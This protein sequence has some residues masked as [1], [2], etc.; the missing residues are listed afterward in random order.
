MGST[1]AGSSSTST[2]PAA[3]GGATSSGAV[4]S[5]TATSVTTGLPDDERTPLHSEEVGFRPPDHLPAS[6]TP[7]SENAALIFERS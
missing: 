2:A 5:A 1:P 3:S 4:T 6:E 7:A